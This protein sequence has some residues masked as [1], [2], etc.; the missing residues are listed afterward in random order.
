[1]PK[2]EI[3]TYAFNVLI[4]FTYKFKMITPRLKEMTSITPSI[5]SFSYEE[6]RAQRDSWRAWGSP[7][8]TVGM[9]GGVWT[10]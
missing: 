6:S 9:E 4:N 2:R 8:D 3:I 7:V 10:P 5:F 1:M